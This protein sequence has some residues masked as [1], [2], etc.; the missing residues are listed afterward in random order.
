M[1]NKIDIDKLIDKVLLK[2]DKELNE[3]M[4]PNQIAVLAQVI[5]KLRKEQD[6][7]K[8]E[9]EL[10][11]RSNNEFFSLLNV[12]DEVEENKKNSKSKTDWKK[13]NLF[14]SYLI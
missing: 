11:E 4:S 3:D 10:E 1:K 12:L 13:L 5:I 2:I 14:Y 8:K 6:L 7:A 9:K